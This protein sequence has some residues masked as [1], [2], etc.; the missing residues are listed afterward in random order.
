M[1][2]SLPI[3]ETNN[4]TS[5]RLTVKVEKDSPCGTPI[6]SAIASEKSSHFMMDA[7]LAIEGLNANG[8]VIGG[9]KIKFILLSEDD[10][11]DPKQGVIIANKLVDAEI[12]AVLEQFNSG[13]TIPASKIYN[14]AGIPNITS[15][16]TSLSLTQAGYKTIFRNIANDGST[17]AKRFKQRFGNDVLVFAPYVYNAIMT[18]ATAMKNAGSVEPAKYLPF[19]ANIYYEGVTVFIFRSGEKIPIPM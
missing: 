7:H 13:T 1:P 14:E 10:Q 11:A 16:A 12:K 6:C 15:S 3:V 5:R 17:F 19:L 2:Q 4:S 18:V 8:L 9:K